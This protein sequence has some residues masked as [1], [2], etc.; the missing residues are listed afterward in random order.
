MQ[1]ETR[2]VKALIIH[3]GKQPNGTVVTEDCIK[4]IYDEQNIGKAL[5]NKIDFEEETICGYLAHTELIFNKETNNLELWGYYVYTYNG[6]DFTNNGLCSYEIAFNHKDKD[7]DE[8]I[9]KASLMYCV[10]INEETGE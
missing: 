6:T 5:L 10:M 3:S 8:T 7:D 4:Q 9:H 2:T 1:K